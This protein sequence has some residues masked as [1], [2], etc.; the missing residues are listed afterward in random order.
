MRDLGTPVLSK[1]FFDAIAQTFPNDL[2][3][4]VAY[5]KDQ[6][7]AGGV[8]FLWNGE[9]EIT[10]ASALRSHN[11]MSPNMLVYWELMESMIRRGA[12]LFNFG[13]CSR[14]S[15]TYRFKMQWGG[16]EEPLWWYQLAPGAE[17]GREAATPS[18]D[19]PG[20]G[21]AVRAWRRLPLS[22]ANRLGPAIVRFI[23]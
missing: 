22:V 5:H 14:D 15:G 20:F 18:P 8:G 2:H 12:R 23:P 3:V 4:A 9:F 10:W 19:R 16:R 13:R 21:L 17:P 7:I 11:A 6:P 1:R